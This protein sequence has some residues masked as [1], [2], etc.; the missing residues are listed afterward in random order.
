[1]QG[2]LQRFSPFLQSWQRGVA[3]TF[4][5]RVIP[6]RYPRQLNGQAEPGGV[7]DNAWMHAELQQEK[8]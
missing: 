5:L 7:F 6:I 1:M 2:S 8:K 3:I 4:W